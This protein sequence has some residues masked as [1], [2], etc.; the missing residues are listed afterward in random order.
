MR[1]ILNFL[2]SFSFSTSSPFR[3]VHARQVLQCSAIP[4]ADILI[5]NLASVLQRDTFSWKVEVI[6]ILVKV[7]HIARQ[8]PNSACPK[9]PEIF[10]PVRKPARIPVDG[11]PLINCN[12]ATLGFKSRFFLLL[13]NVY[14]AIKRC[15]RNA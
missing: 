8:M 9:T 14:L 12:S 15:D 10:R 13:V 11:S 3:E 4:V 6:I 2:F 1:K 7:P 5:P